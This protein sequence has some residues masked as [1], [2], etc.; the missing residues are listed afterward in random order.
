VGAGINFETNFLS[1]SNQYLRLTLSFGAQAS[2]WYSIA[3]FGIGPSNRTQG[4]AIGLFESTSSYVIGSSG[5]LPTPGTGAVYYRR[6]WRDADFAIIRWEYKQTAAGSNGTGTYTLPLPTGI[7]I[8]STK[9]GVNT[10]I[11]FIKVSGDGFWYNG[12]TYFRAQ[13]YYN[14]ST[15]VGVLLSNE[16]TSPSTTWGAS[17]GAFSG[18]G[19][20][21]FAFEIRVP[22]AEWASSALNL[23][24]G[25]QEYYVSNSLTDTAAGAVNAV[26][27]TVYGPAGS[28]ILSINSTALSNTSSFYMTPMYPFQSNDL[29][30][31][32]I[33]NN[34]SQWLPVGS[35]NYA[36]A[37]QGSSFYGVGLTFVTSTLL[38]VEFGNGGFRGNNATYGLAGQAWSAL[39]GSRWRVRVCKASSPVGFGLANVDGSAGLY[40]AGSAPGLATGAA[41]SAGNI[42]EVYTQTWASVQITTSGVNLCT[43]SGVQNGNYLVFIESD[44]GFSS[45]TRIVSPPSGWTTGTATIVWPTQTSAGEWLRALESATAVWNFVSTCRVTTAGTIIVS[46]ASIGGNTTSSCRGRITLMRIA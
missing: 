36:V 13:P 6:T 27:G 37:N 46:V 22:I 41:I 11:S 29:A 35:G 4:P 9:I 28:A 38:I 26:G 12:S 25:A 10:G 7:T 8:D 31:L 40:K 30:V 42:G 16:T 43:I 17:A 44:V 5:T 3:Q 14:T 32:E 33:T 1:T 2:A 39:A 23:G 24:P 15:S 45:A 18:S 21:E 34:G 19:N 20:T